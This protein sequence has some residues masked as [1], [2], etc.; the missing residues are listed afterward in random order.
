MGNAREI[1]RRIKSV[2]DTKQITRAMKMVAAAKLRRA[3]NRMMAMRPYADHLI[4]MIGDVSMDLF[5]DEHPLFSVRPEKAAANIVIAG[6]KGLCGGFNTTIIRHAM[7]HFD[8]LPEVEHKLYSIGKRA[9]SAFTKQKREILHSYSDVFDSLSYILAEEICGELVS[10]FMAGEIDS[11]YVVYNRFVSVVSQEP[12]VEQILP[13]DFSAIVTA[14]KEREE[15]HHS[16]LEEH[17]REQTPKRLVY[18][19]EPDPHIVMESLMA[20]MIAT[21]VYRATL[22]SYAAELG[23]RMSAMDSATSNAEDMIDKLTMEYNRARQTGIT[24]ELLD[25]VG[26]AE[27]LKG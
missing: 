2:E 18:D 26:G 16:A 20:R 21:R 12:I 10:K 8:S 4:Q 19:F 1:K 5:G 15:A 13:V 14:R 11:A 24:S 3:Q 22:E 23:A 7:Q 25:I 17:E 9:T 6:D 27:S